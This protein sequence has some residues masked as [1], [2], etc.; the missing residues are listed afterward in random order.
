MARMILHARQIFDERRHAR[1]G[2]EVGL[3]TVSAGTRQQRLG[4]LQGLP[5]RQ[6]GFPACR[7]LA[8]QRPNPALLPDSLPS[9][10]NLPRHPK[11]TGHFRRGILPGKQPARLLAA[12]F[13]RGMISCLS[14]AKTLPRNLTHVTLLR[15]T[16]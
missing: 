10:S 12:L 14:H 9:V 1:Q 7:S 2:P 11:T 8:G 5:G 6:P 4:D 13:H 16:Q 15:E 3:V